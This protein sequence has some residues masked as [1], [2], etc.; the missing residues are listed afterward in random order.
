MSEKDIDLSKG[1]TLM[2]YSYDNLARYRFLINF[3]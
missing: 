2:S 3:A 1:V